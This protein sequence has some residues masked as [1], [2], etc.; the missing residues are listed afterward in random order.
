MA[1]A[2][3]TVPVA[4]W[5]WM[6]NATSA[7][8]SGAEELLAAPAAGVSIIVRHLTISSGA[9]ITIS[10][11]EGETVPGTIDTTFIGPTNFAA[12]A[13]LQWTFGNGGMLLTAA[14]NLVVDASGAGNINV[15][16]WGIYR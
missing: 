15:F 4:Y 2:V 8:A 16:G 7:N 6:L 10:I 12:N 11:G 5:G 9:A 3:T 13:F 1:I 14:T